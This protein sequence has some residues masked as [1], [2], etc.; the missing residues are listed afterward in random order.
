MVMERVET[1]GEDIPAPSITV[2]TSKPNIDLTYYRSQALSCLSKNNS[3]DCFEDIGDSTE[4]L[5]SL[6]PQSPEFSEW[7]RSYHSIAGWMYF[8]KGSMSMKEVE[9]T[10]SVIESNLFVTLGLNTTDVQI[11]IHDKNQFLHYYNDLKFTL[12]SGGGASKTIFLNIRKIRKVKNCESTPGYS[13]S[14]CIED[15]I[16]KVLKTMT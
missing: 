5:L 15:F 8:R 2:G 14:G 13:F 9:D 6:S 7:T 12:L 1:D 3:M 10:N 4:K 16:T 11:L